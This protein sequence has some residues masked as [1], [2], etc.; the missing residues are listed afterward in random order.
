MHWAWTVIAN[1]YEG[2]WDKASAE[3]RDAAITWRAAYHRHLSQY[4]LP[5]VPHRELS[6]E[7]EPWPVEDRDA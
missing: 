2:D 6:A 4:G 5:P 1:A 7:D 3:W